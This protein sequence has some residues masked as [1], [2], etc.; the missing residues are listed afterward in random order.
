M[1]NVNSSHSMGIVNREK[2]RQV[3][4]VEYRSFL[5]VIQLP[6]FGKRR[7]RNISSRVSGGRDCIGEGRMSIAADQKIQYIQ[8][9]KFTL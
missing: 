2:M 5:P 6:R 3:R 8:G 9:D 7:Y 1:V 4:A